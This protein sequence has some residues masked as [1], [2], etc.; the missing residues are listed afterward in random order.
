MKNKPDKWNQKDAKNQQKKQNLDTAKD[1]KQNELKQD[2]QSKDQ[3]Y[4]QDYQKQDLQ[5]KGKQQQQGD[6]NLE[7]K[8][9]DVQN[10]EGFG[11]L[12]DQDQYTDQ[13]AKRDK[14]SQEGR[15][16]AENDEFE[17]QADDFS[18]EESLE[19]EE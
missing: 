11:I 3:Q 10:Q 14:R 19:E 16:N 15:A 12:G 6:K 4:Q 1:Q 8:N 13:M 5:A 2:Q 7:A 9:K 18:E 17:Q